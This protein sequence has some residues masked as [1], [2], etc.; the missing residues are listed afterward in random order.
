[1]RSSDIVIL[2]IAAACAGCS[3]TGAAPAGS[4]PAPVPVSAQS[5]GG[6]SGLQ[7]VTL[8]VG[9]NAQTITLPAIRESVWPQ[10]AA[11]YESLGIPLT[12]KDDAAF[13]LGNE[14]FKAR[15]AINGLQLRTALDCGSDLTGE[16]A[17]TYEIRLTVES[18]LAAST[19]GNATDLTTNVSGIGRSASV[20]GSDVTCSTR[21]EIERRIQ[22][23]VRMQL[24][25]PA[26]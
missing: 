9:G 24:G 15:R 25:L 20:S 14:Q 16:K 21:G 22:R 6:N 1:V 23:F 2:G 13:R 26:K 5:G 19:N 11:A 17:E 10:L 4:S 18:S 7:G 12:Y 8:V 3:S